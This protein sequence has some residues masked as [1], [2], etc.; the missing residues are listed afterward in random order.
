MRD[1]HAASLLAPDLS[2]VIVS[3]NTRDLLRE[4]VTELERQAVDISHETI[5]VDNASRDSSADMIAA[6]FPS[7]QLIRNQLNLGFAAANN[8]AFRRA[9]GRYFVLLNS[10]AF[11]R[12]GALQRAISHMD[13]TPRAGVGG[14]RLVGR[15]DS[16]QPSARMFP[17]LLNEF[18][19]MS[20]LASRF[21]RSRFLGRADRTWAD[22]AEA[23]AVD[24]VP[25]AF[26]IIRRE[27]LER[28]GYFDERF[29]LYYEEIDLCRRVKAA[30]YEV[31]YWPDIVAVHLGG[32]SSKTLNELELSASGSQ[33][34]QWRMRSGLLFYRKHHGLLGA[35]AAMQLELLW[36]HLR[37]QRN[38]YSRSSKARRNALQSRASIAQMTQAWRETRGGTTSPPHPW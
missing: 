26:S 7:V 13:E 23:A 27:V 9:R 10:D 34:S 8:I 33:L 14:G 12:P 38:S 16:W 29:F 36:N 22:P 24:W 1:A 28:I 35:W 4:C 5:V 20:G 31:W 19:M 17:S 15:D 21:P 2:V 37:V 18:L 30:G 11:I 3:F 32:E 6:E 25:G